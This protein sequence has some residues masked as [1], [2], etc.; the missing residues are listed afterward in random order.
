MH[1]CRLRLPLLQRT[2]ASPGAPAL[3]SPFRISP[4]RV[5]P[6]P[7]HAF[8]PRPRHR[9]SS[10][11]ALINLDCVAKSPPTA[12]RRFFSTSTYLMYVFA[13]EKPPSL[14]GR[15]FC[16]AIL[17]SFCDAINLNRFYI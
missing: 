6:D 12:L 2:A 7:V 14:V 10:R 11:I 8:A 16:L 15:N 3:F 4:V 5:D 17:L 9:L 13:T 1:R